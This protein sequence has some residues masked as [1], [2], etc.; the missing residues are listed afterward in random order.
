M[1]ERHRRERNARAQGRIWNGKLPKM[2]NQRSGCFS[3]IMEKAEPASESSGATPRSR[4]ATAEGTASLNE[5][6]PAS[7]Q[8]EHAVDRP[9]WDD[10]TVNSLEIIDKMIN[11]PYYEG[12]DP[13]QKDLT[14]YGRWVIREREIQDPTN[15]VNALCLF[16]V[17]KISNMWSVFRE[18]VCGPPPRLD[19][20]GYAD[21]NPGESTRSLVANVYK[22]LFA[23]QGAMKLHP[24]EEV[25]ERILAFKEGRKMKGRDA[26]WKH[27]SNAYARGGSARA[28]PCLDII[29][30]QVVHY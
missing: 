19:H 8:C 22:S 11:D 16:R 1:R 4:S 21:P 13:H 20:H 27:E 30:G 3:L 7:E 26:A 5:P 29:K 15:C 14:P 9:P 23:D 24:W 2:V 18:I 28:K 17:A 10:A 6:T 12:L 25:E